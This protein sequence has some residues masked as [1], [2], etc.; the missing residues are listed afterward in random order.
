[1]TAKGYIYVNEKLGRHFCFKGLKGGGTSLKVG[2]PWLWKW[3]WHNCRHYSSIFLVG[4]KK[5]K[6][7]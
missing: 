2:E 1:M 5:I 6:K 7:I 3:L 4:P